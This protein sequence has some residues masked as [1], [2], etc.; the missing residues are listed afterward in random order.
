MQPGG[1]DPLER[2]SFP[3]DEPFFDTI[4]AADPEDLVDVLF[5]FLFLENGQGWIHATPGPPRA[6]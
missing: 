1:G 5:T 2:D 4:G 3:F 6:D